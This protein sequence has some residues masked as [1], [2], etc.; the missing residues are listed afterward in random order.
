MSNVKEVEWTVIFNFPEK[1]VYPTINETY[2]E[3]MNEQVKCWDNKKQAEEY[4]KEHCGKYSWV[5]VPTV[6][7]TKIYDCN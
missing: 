3:T 2:Q 5:L 6:I 7:E 1:P 4:A